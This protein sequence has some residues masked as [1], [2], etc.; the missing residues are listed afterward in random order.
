MHNH[1]RGMTTDEFESYVKHKEL[2]A[3]EA[4]AEAEIAA[5]LLEKSEIEAERERVERQRREEKELWEYEMRLKKA[6]LFA[7]IEMMSP[8]V[9]NALNYEEQD[10]DDEF[11]AEEEGENGDFDFSFEED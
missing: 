10:A 2:Q 9:K 7:E 1:D 3:R 8:N 6:R 5:K 4:A 11:P